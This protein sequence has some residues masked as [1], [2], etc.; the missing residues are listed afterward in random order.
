MN[1]IRHYIGVEKI[2]EVPAVEW[3]VYM[4]CSTIWVSCLIF[5]VVRQFELRLIH[6]NFAGEDESILAIE[7]EQFRTTLDSDTNR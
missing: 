4:I 2:P 5:L 6:P 1:L 3:S 7:M